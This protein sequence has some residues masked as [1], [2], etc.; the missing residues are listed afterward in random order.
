MTGSRPAAE[1]SNEIVRALK[2][3]ATRGSGGS[4]NVVSTPNLKI[5]LNVRKQERLLENNSR[6]HHGQQAHRHH[7]ERRHRTHGHQPAPGALHPRDPRTGRHPAPRRNPPLARPHPGR[8][9]R[10]QTPPVSRS[11]RS[12]PLHHRSSLLPGR[13]RQHHLFR[14]PNHLPSRTRPA[15]GDRGR[16]T[17]LLRKARNRHSCLRPSIWPASPKPA[18]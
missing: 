2:R 3:A 10:I 15:R 9:Q 14:R 6:K 1:P 17:R 13:P 7:H 12:L 8:P 11:S 5:P 16:Q 4:P 18:A